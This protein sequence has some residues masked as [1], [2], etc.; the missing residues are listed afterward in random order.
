MA[1]GYFGEKMSDLVKN[2]AI[3]PLCAHFW[4]IKVGSDLGSEWVKTG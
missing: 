2:L 4:K 1:I 3:C